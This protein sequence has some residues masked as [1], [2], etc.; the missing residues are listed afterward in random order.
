MSSQSRASTQEKYATNLSSVALGTALYRPVQFKALSGRVGDIA[1]IDKEGIYQWIA[2]A[3]DNE[4]LTY[5]AGLRL[6]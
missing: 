1:F 2:N 6:M 4:V 5:M 3:F